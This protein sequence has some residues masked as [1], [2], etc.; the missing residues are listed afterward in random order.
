MEYS[1][2]FGDGQVNNND[3]NPSHTYA[4]A[5]IYQ[6][7]VTAKDEDGC[8]ETIC[9]EITFDNGECLLTP[10][11]N[12]VDASS[13]EGGNITSFINGNILQ[14]V[15]WIVNGNLIINTDMTFI[16]VELKM[17]EG[18]SIIVEPGKKFKI[19]ANSQIY[20]CI[21]M[22]KG[23]FFSVGGEY[24][25]SNSTISDAETAVNIKEMATL[26]LI[27][28]TFDK[29][30]IS[31]EAVDAAYPIGYFSGNTFDCTANLLPPYMGQ[32]LINHGAVS[33][34]GARGNSTGFYDLKF[35]DNINGIDQSPNIFQNIRNGVIVFN[36]TALRCEGNQFLN[37][38]PA[39]LNDATFNSNFTVT[40][41]F[42]YN[43]L[44]R[45]FKGVRLN[46]PRRTFIMTGNDIS[47]YNVKFENSLSAVCNINAPK[48][49]FINISNNPN[50][51]NS[52]LGFT[53]A[54]GTA[55][56][57]W[58]KNN[59]LL[60]LK[61]GFY[62][63][64]L[65]ARSIKSEHN[66]ITIN[67]SEP[68]NSDAAIS[69]YNSNGGDAY[70]NNIYLNGNSGQFLTGIS[71]VFSG[72]GVVN[73][74]HIYDQNPSNSSIGI[75]VRASSGVEFYCNKIYDTEYGIGFNNPCPETVLETTELNNVKSYS[76]SLINTEISPQL[77]N[78]NTFYSGNGIQTKAFLD[79]GTSNYSVDKSRI[80]YNSNDPSP[81]GLLAPEV[82]DILP[83]NQVWFLDEALSNNDKCVMGIYNINV[84]KIEILEDIAL[85]NVLANEYYL[86]N[87]WT[88][89]FQLLQ[90]LENN[91]AI[92]DSSNELSN[93]YYDNSE[94]RQY[95][96][97][98]NTIMN[99]TSTSEDTQ[100]EL[101]AKCEEFDLHSE[102]LE[103]LINSLFN[104][105]N[106]QQ[107][108]SALLMKTNIMDLHNH[109]GVLY[110]SILTMQHANATQLFSN[111]NNLVESENFCSQFKTVF[112]A[113]ID[114][115][116]FGQD[117]VNSNYGDSLM[118]IAEMCEFEIGIPVYLAQSI[119]KILG[120][121]YESN[122]NNC[123]EN[124][125]QL[126]RDVMKDNTFLIN[127][128]PVSDRVFIS[129]IQPIN[130]ISVINSMG[131]KC[132]F[133][134]LKESK[135]EH[136]MDLSFLPMG[137]YF[138]IISSDINKMSI[139]KIVKI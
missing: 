60:N 51:S 113:K 10:D 7:C 88:T 139:Y 103:N 95:F 64:D 110:D 33:Y 96:D 4:I 9:R 68:V 127:P 36:A 100:L 74:N 65:M 28:N 102:S 85:G 73:E 99:L 84:N 104:I 126:N 134:L 49:A 39:H 138:I 44:N 38:L 50:V 111:V 63:H 1:W 107:I 8:C 54:N 135:F 86:Q 70:N 12:Y 2:N 122:A 57:V 92:L 76:L 90:I 5:G 81:N 116:R 129:G 108:D 105:P 121:G 21:T 52:H 97:V 101:S 20:G 89:Q 48:N 26:H 67:S 98:F 137:N 61:T 79:L 132:Y 93:F 16:H 106:S 41:H 46:E 83:T 128:N 80:I 31:I 17:A 124:R 14:D 30:W 66:N 131:V 125:I 75:N 71:N 114:L 53:I 136:E 56:D 13:P 112:K 37:L 15:K 40:T 22:W 78:G 11:F 34:C 47:D 58:F 42:K 23:I 6:V 109:I 117:Y 45:G 133:K 24:E 35:D 115:F 59:T 43:I 69:Y 62:T 32:P 130:S 3:P 25:I 87:K 77:Y 91:L 120:I 29:N 72:F 123:A 118:T 18:S 94:A 19:L 82:I 119:C 55:S 27:G